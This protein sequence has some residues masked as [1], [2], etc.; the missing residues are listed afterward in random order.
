MEQTSDPQGDIL[1]AKKVYTESD[2]MAWEVYDAVIGMARM[3]R[4]EAQVPGAS[5][6][7]AA[8]QSAEAAYEAAIAPA[9][10]VYVEAL[11]QVGTVYTDAQAR[12]ALAR[13]EQ[14]ANVYAIATEPA[15]RACREAINVG[16]KAFQAAAE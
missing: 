4:F 5:F 11:A 13:R 16:M 8:E 14:A 3:A 10:A 6:S 7:D 2:A 15:L 9:L 1:A 12:V